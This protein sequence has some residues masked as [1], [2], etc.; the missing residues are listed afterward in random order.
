MTQPDLT[1]HSDPEPAKAMMS[2]LNGVFVARL[3][4][5]AADLGLADCIGDGS[6]DVESL[7]R[8]TKARAP[9]LAR[10]LRAL[11]AIGIVNESAE[12]YY[13][14]TPLGATLRN[15]VSGSMRAWA[16]LVFSDDQG[17]AWE[18]LSHAVRTGDHAFRHIFGTDLWTR[19]AARP[20]AA[21][22][23]DA[24]MQSLTQGVY[25]H[26]TLTYPFEKFSWIVDVGGGNGALLLP[27]AERHPAMR[28]TVFD[29]PHVADAARARIA[30]AGLADRCDA[31]GGDAFVAVPSGADA[32]VLKG[33]IHDWEDKDAIAILR[34][35]RSAMPEG[36]KLLLIERILPERIDPNDAATRER[37]IADIQMFVNPG[38]RERTEAEFR[39]LLTQAGLRL[40]G[41]VNTMAPQAII[42]VDLA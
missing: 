9:S 37:F 24:A 38:G 17:R 3:V 26:L 19:L 8:A 34:S 14:L 15:D 33:V 28:L 39:V 27:V 41:I 30:A 1:G 29:F 32:Y 18:A 4:H 42:E 11:T 40:T 10:L 23:F 16:L 12:R 35:C 31:V 20:E 5:A 2:L 7:A 6:R 36:A 13:T 22:L 25:R 21:R